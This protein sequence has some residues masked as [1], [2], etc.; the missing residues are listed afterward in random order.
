MMNFEWDHRKAA[1]NLRKHGVSF[2]EAATVLDDPL[3]I[4]YAPTST[5]LPGVAAATAAT[6]WATGIRRTGQCAF[7]SPMMAIVRPV[8]FCS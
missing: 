3:A 1:E 6:T 5:T 7:P 2:H 8:R 4:T